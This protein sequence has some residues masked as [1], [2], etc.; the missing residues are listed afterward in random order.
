MIIFLK[1][2]VLVKFP[3]NRKAARSCKELTYTLDLPTIY[4]LWHFIIPTIFFLNVLTLSPSP[5]KVLQYVLP[6]KKNI[7]F[8]NNHAITQI[9][10][11]T[12][13]QCGLHHPPGVYAMISG[14][15][16]CFSLFPFAY[17]IFAHS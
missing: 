13:T 10:N 4:I 8:H 15:Q 14:A 3:A 2:F 6:K 9:R 5:I 11:L 17:K 7:L 1:P 12:E 16:P